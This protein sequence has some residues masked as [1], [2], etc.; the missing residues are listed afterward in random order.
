M[1]S[2]SIVVIGVS[3]SGKTTIGRILA[4]RLAVPFIDGDDLHGAENVAKMARGEPLTDEDRMPWLDRVAAALASGTRAGGGVVV[5]CSALRARYRERLREV[6]GEVL[7]IVHLDGSQDLI[8]GRLAARQ[9]HFMPAG[10]LSSQFAALEPP[11]A[12]TDVLSVSIDRT[13]GE[14]VEAILLGLA[15]APATPRRSAE[16]SRNTPHDQISRPQP[17]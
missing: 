16:S 3:G 9:G 17:P 1:S 10:L 12:E 8:A 5:T 14:I 13:E 15:N 7:T 4:A 6:V 2:R 11:E